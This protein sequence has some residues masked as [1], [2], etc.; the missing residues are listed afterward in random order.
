[1]LKNNKFIL[2]DRDGVINKDPG[3]WTEHS[4]VTKWEDF[5]FLPGAIEALRIL[6]ENGIKV[7]VVSNQAGVGKNY[8]SE[9]DLKRVNSLMMKEVEKGGGKIEE[10]YYCIHRDDDACDCR[11][12][13]TGLFEK[14]AKKYGIDLK[15]TYIVGD[16]DVDIEAGRRLGMKTIFV[17]SGKVSKE[18]IEKWEEKPDYVFNDLLDAVNRIIDKGTI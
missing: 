15:G 13:K 14:A 9:K 6:K 4:Y 8:F 11:K 1:M 18:E 12:P 16:S 17:L 10:A 2:I 5:Y 3:G 7:V